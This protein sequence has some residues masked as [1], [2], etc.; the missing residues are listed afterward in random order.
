MRGHANGLASPGLDSIG[1]SETG[2]RYEAQTSS[3]LPCSLIRGARGSVLKLLLPVLASQSGRRR[4][5]MTRDVRVDGDTR[6]DIE[7]VSR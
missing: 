7:L 5:A 6:F 1:W 3:N 2:G 4:R